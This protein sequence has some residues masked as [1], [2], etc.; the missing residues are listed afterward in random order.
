VIALQH[1]G[2]GRIDL[3]QLDLQWDRGYV[4]QPYATQTQI[5]ET[6]GFPWSEYSRSSIEYSDAVC[7]VIFTSGNEVIGWFEHPRGEGDLATY[8]RKEGYGSQDAI[9]PP[10]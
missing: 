1:L 5:D 2:D 4:F 3:S 8:Y 7:L 9:F 6:L 10:Q